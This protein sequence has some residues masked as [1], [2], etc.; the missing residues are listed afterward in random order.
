MKA[1]II[2]FQSAYNYGAV[3]QAYALQNYISSEFAEIKIL[4]YHNEKI[5]SAYARPCFRDFLC[6]PK[7]A[8][9][10]VIQTIIFKGKREKID[11]FCKKY[12]IL[13]KRY[14][15]CNISEASEI[16]D[17]F[18]TGS[19]Q[20]WNYLIV[21]KDG[22]YYLDFVKNKKTCSYA[23]SFGVSSIPKEYVEFYRNMLN[24]VNHI[25]VREEKGVEL[26]EQLTSKHAVVMP[27]PTLLIDMEQW[28]EISISPKQ[29]KP[30][31]LVYKIT[32]ADCLLK[33]AKQISRKTGFPIIYIPND[34]KDG[35]IGKL[36]TNIGPREW[37]GYI[38][39]AEYVIT[40]SFHGAVF[41]IIFRRKFFVEASSR[42]NVSTSRLNSLLKLFGLE[43]RL[44]ESYSDNML[45]E[46]V[47][48]ELISRIL[49]KQC[50]QANQF[51]KSVFIVREN[52]NV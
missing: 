32:K 42:T 9:F 7:N 23:A 12:F 38:Q 20:V 27:D 5:D 19:D 3:L 28:K 29:T 47:C 17:V 49:E 10:K 16:A 39:N 13:S 44:L 18:I 41:S 35:L 6:N 2:T 30:Y 25:S 34:L 36:N 14:D 31:I 45:K 52:E 48:D 11:E 33:F 46:D 51:F 21:G 15:K 40:N 26:V 1:C 37:L 4:D 8:V 50:K 22:S 43:N 24:N